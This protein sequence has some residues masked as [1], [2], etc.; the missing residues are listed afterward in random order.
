MF[1]R[2]ISSVY[3]NFISMKIS[4]IKNSILFIGIALVSFL[5][6][7]FLTSLF[8]LPSQTKQLIIFVGVLV[9]TNVATMLWLIRNY[10][11]ERI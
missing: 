2:L 3:K 9:S 8:E 7:Q 10:R 5:V 4:Q 11:K 1:S 6:F